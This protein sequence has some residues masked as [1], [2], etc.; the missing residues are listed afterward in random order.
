MGIFRGRPPRART[1]SSTPMVPYAVVE[2]QSMILLHPVPGGSVQDILRAVHI[3]VL[4][5]YDI[6]D[7]REDVGRMNDAVDVSR[8]EE[9]VQIVADIASEKFK[10]AVRNRG[11][12]D[13]DSGDVCNFWL[14]PEEAD[15][16]LPEISR[17]TG[18]EDVLHI[19]P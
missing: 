11:L 1:I 12:F 3:D 8:Q 14:V 6:M 7:R 10:L 13:I 2:E 4:H 5:Q 18:N 19:A 16:P 17:N 15:K 9:P